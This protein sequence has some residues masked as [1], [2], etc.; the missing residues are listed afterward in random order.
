MC[1]YSPTS[2]E[3]HCNSFEECTCSS[4]CYTAV[5]PTRVY[6]DNLGYVSDILQLPAK[7]CYKMPQKHCQSLC[8][9]QA[10]SFAASMLRV[11]PWSLAAPWP[12]EILGGSWLGIS[13]VISR[14][15]IVITHI[16]GL[17]TP[18]ITTHEPPSSESILGA[19]FGTREPPV[20]TTN[21]QYKYRY[22]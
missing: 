13:G 5:I 12:V 16:R 20:A 2:T 7:V 14:V 1:L 10:Q 21:D 18:L 19:S 9:G 17:I 4:L 22:T 8:D 6:Y 15:T 11:S 3:I